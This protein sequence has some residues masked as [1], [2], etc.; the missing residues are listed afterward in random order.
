MHTPPIT[1][2]ALEQQRAYAAWWTAYAQGKA[3]GCA[4]AAQITAAHLAIAQATFDPAA[5]TAW[6]TLGRWLLRWHTDIIAEPLIVPWVAALVAAVLRAQR[7]PDAALALL[8]AELAQATG[9]ARLVADLSASLARL[10]AA[11]P[12][13]PAALAAL[14][15][16]LLKAFRLTGDGEHRRLG[17][18]IATEIVPH[19]APTQ[20]ELCVAAYRLSHAAPFAAAAAALLAGPAADFSAAPALP[21]LLHCAYPDALIVGGYAGP[22]LFADRAA[23]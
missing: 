3:A 13:E 14:G 5:I 10:A 22:L 9:D 20:A 18:H 8:L 6:A 12:A 15:V 17:L 11:P 16:A 7:P 4:A 2:V 19:A 23:G 1:A 21:A